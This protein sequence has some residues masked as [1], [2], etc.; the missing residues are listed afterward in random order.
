MAKG[1]KL[2]TADVVL[3]DIGAGLKRAEWHLQE[4]NRH[5]GKDER[6]QVLRCAMVDAARQELHQLQAQI[7]GR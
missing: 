2:T 4:F 5:G 7:A 1:T 3:S 6:S